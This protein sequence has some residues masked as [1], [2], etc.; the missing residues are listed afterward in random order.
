MAMFAQNLLLL[1]MMAEAKIPDNSHLVP[2][3]TPI[4]LLINPLSPGIV[5]R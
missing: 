3:Y 5:V 1:G 4:L 2:Y